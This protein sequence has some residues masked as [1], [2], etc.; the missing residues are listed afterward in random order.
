MMANIYLSQDRSVRY[1]A[2]YQPHYHYI[3]LSCKAWR[4]RR[5]RWAP[6][7]V[8]LLIFALHA[9]ASL[10]LAVN[11]YAYAVLFTLFTLQSTGCPATPAMNY[12][13]VAYVTLPADR[14]SNAR[15]CHQH[16]KTWARVSGPYSEVCQLIDL[17][18]GGSFGSWSCL[19]GPFCWSCSFSSSLVCPW[20]E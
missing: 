19:V 8:H 1:A 2:A 18:G 7:P 14:G 10:N 17:V 13:I 15:S 20:L 6:R 12:D 9:A 5:Q 4:P 3:K 16:Q 11:R